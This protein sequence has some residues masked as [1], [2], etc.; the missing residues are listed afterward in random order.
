[1]DPPLAMMKGRDGVIRDLYDRPV[2]VVFNSNPTCSKRHELEDD[3]TE[4]HTQ[5]LEF[6]NASGP[7]IE[8]DAARTLIRTHV[9]ADYKRRRML[10]KARVRM[11]QKAEMLRHAVQDRPQEENDYNF[12]ISNPPPQPGGGL[13]PFAKYPVQM[14]QN[15]YKLIQHYF[16]VIVPTIIEPGWKDPFPLAMTDAAFFHMFLLR[17]ALHANALRVDIVSSEIIFHKF[18]AIQ[19]VN[20]RLQNA[21]DKISNST[22]MTIAF[23]ALAECAAGDYKAWD[24]HMNGLREIIE[25]KGGMT[26]LDKSLQHAIYRFD[27]LGCIE[28]NCGLRFPLSV[29]LLYKYR[30]TSGPRVLKL[31]R[32]LEAIKKSFSL[33][34]EI[35]AILNDLQRLR[36]TVANLSTLHASEDIT[37]TTTALRHR[38]LLCTTAASN[39][40]NEAC[41]LAALIYLTPALSCQ[42]TYKGLLE[43]LKTCL[44]SIKT[45]PDM[46]RYEV[47]EFAFWLL[48]L[49]GAIARDDLNRSWFVANLCE[50]AT[51]LHVNDWDDVESV[52]MKFFWLEKLHKEPFLKI[53]KEVT[54]ARNVIKWM[55]D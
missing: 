27:F 48:F 26:M 11:K 25:M 47:A 30:I 12:R 8:D 23:L 29:D 6:I 28:S 46:T 22:I 52:L 53:W 31:P 19:L 5:P 33:D 54:M 7:A 2:I 40:L 44:E 35:T 34:S 16:A 18:K 20:S 41:R 15:M 13:D 14:H 4:G 43:N 32:G 36:I 10:Q 24:L 21:A 49:G 9:M 45:N 1:M 50:T 55:G 39:I 3:D 38:L 17:S 42:T 51:L 37:Y